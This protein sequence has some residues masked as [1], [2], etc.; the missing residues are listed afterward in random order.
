MSWLKDSLVDFWQRGDKLLLSLCLCASG[1]G[2]ILIYSATRYLTKD[3][4]RSVIIQAV[5]ILLGIGVYIL[6]SSVDVELLTEKSWKLMF[7]F[8]LG[9]NLL[10]RTPLGVE[11]GGNRNWIRIPGFPMNI[12]PAEITKLTFI[13]LFAYQCAKLQKKEIGRAHV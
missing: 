8:N 10:V 2:L 6:L 13:L 12:Q 1:Y 3:Q 9:F 11:N 4:N 7:L 5:G